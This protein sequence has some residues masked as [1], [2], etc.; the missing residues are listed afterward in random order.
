MDGAS[1]RRGSD[2]IKSLVAWRWAL[3]ANRSDRWPYHGRVLLIDCYNLLHTPAPAR[4]S[5]LDEGGLCRAL[6]GT[7]WT[8]GAVIVVADGRPK[9]LRD[10]VSPVPEVTLRYT[11]AGCS[12]DDWII[13]AVE[14]HRAPRSIT[15]VTNDRTIQLNVRSHGARVCSCQAFW[16]QLQQAPPARGGSGSPRPGGKTETGLLSAEQRDR[17]LRELGLDA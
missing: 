8:S 3:G 2:G 12:A 11:G 15:V 5:G 13:D 4:F 10:A 17:W 14:R 9:P 6:G 7:R 1:L 16:Q